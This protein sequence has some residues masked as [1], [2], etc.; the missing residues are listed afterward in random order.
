MMIESHIAERRYLYKSLT[1]QRISLR[2]PILR[3]CSYLAVALLLATPA[4]GA[5]ARIEAAPEKKPPGA[6]EVGIPRIKT[7]VPG[8][9]LLLPYYLVEKN[10][11]SGAST[12]FAVR[13]ESASP[14]DITISYFET[15]RPQTAQRVENVT[16]AAKQVKTVQ[17]RDVPDL[18][19]DGD[20]FARGFVIFETV[21]G[22]AALQGDYFQV[23]PGEGFAS[24][25]RLLNI[26]P[27]SANNELCRRFTA[28]Y[29]NGGAFSGGT[30]FF[31]W[32]QSDGPPSSET[33]VLFY[34]LYG[35]SGETVFNAAVHSDRVA[36]TE[37][38]ATLVTLGPVSGPNFGVIEF[39]F[40]ETVG[41]I[42]AVLDASGLY[43][44]G[45]DA[46]C[47]DNSPF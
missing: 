39:E 32:L 4:S 17:I 44:V 1:L 26:D 2:R 41:H 37:K 21:D 7:E 6:T 34:T 29:L 19:V 40:N 16:L 27:I 24:G 38:A 47:M 23:T 3:R 35:E 33:P 20:G 31:I 10:N 5:G 22:S 42:A 8:A 12:L 15:D 9:R 36:F 43:S 11:I 46:V 25:D 14:V 30:S 18:L 28:R 13:N 45:I